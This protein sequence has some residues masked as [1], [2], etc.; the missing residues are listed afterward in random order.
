MRIDKIIKE[1]RKELGFTQEQVVQY[2]GISAPAVNKWE[3]RNIYSDIMLLP[4]LAR[5][6]KID[7]NTLLSFN[8]DLSKQEIIIFMNEFLETLHKKG[9]KVGYKM[10]MKKIQEYP[11][12]DK[13]INSIAMSLEGVMIMLGVDNKEEYEDKIEKLYECTVNSSDADIS[14]GSKSMMISKYIKREEC[15]KRKS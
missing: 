14:N 9:A 6:L 15:E 13:L 12:C 4:A 11:N 8:E 3:N 2:L 5:L 7:L 1:K 10:G